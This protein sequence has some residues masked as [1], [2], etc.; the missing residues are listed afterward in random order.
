[1]SFDLTVRVA[2][3]ELGAYLA[4]PATLPAPVVIVV[5]EIFGVTDGIRRIADG[6]AEAGYVA[7]APDLFWRFAPGIT[8]SEH[9]EHDWQTALGYYQRLDLD[10]AVADL[11]AVADIARRLPEGNGKVGVMG[12]CLGGLLAFLAA[13]H[14]DAAVDYYGSRTDEFVEYAAGGKTPLLLHLAG[15]DEFMDSAARARIVDALNG[16]PGVEIHQYPG[17]SH[18]FARPLGDHFHEGDAALAERRTRTFLAQH[19]R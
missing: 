16:M 4:R 17:R 11:D 1:M 14:V 12:F 19:L 8:L 7:V 18:A 13:D 2:D 5:Q 3:G 6:L 9:S 10:L 15:N